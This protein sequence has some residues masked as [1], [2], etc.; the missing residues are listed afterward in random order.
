MF[1]FECLWFITRQLG[2]K[3]SSDLSNFN[4]IAIESISKMTSQTQTHLL[5]CVFII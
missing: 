2:K 5:E 1:V 3:A 4:S